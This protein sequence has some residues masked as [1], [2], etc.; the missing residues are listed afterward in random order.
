MKCCAIVA[1]RD[2]LKRAGTHL[3]LLALLGGAAFSQ[4]TTFHSQ[5]NVVVIPALVKSAH[6]EAVYGL[7]AKDFV[8]EDDGEEQALHVDEAAEGQPVSMV[9][10]IQ[11]GRRADYEFPRIR[12]LSAMLDP[13]VAEGHG[14]VAIVE[15]DST[16]QSAQE[17]TAR[18]E[19]IAS[20]LKELQPGD[21]GAAILD[22]VDYSVKMLEL[23]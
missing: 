3:L 14:S 22:A 21:D 23:A 18:S 5:S 4:E 1:R 13:L 8:V 6:G 15:F 17:F 2:S 19:K 10:A 20:T 16:V 11:R 7:T 12:G 9:I